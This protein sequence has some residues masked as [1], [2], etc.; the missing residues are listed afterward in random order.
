MSYSVKEVYR[1]IQG[2]GRHSGTACVFLRF[3]GCNAWSGRE[4]DRERDS[5]KAVCAR[6]CDTD[7]VGTD[8]VGGGRYLAA[9]KLADVVCREWGDGLDE[10]IVV[11]TGGEPSL[12][13]DDAL[14]YE[15]VLRG[16]RVHVETNGSHA[17]PGGCAWVTLSPKPPLPIVQQHYDEVKVVFGG[18][19][20]DVERWRMLAPVR[21]LMPLWSENP[22][23]RAACTARCAAYVSS[24]P[25]WRMSVQL[26]KFAGL[27]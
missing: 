16:F 17:L 22:E 20:E 11:V 14:I 24:H 23:E 5:A 8:G 26:H 18:V 3:S 13:L 9:D 1:S 15:L 21:Y 12:Q 4:A 27:R 10:R 6:W 25:S 2:E 7:F 19:G